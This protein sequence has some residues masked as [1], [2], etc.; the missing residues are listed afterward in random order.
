MAVLHRAETGEM[1]L[2]GKHSEEARKKM[3]NAKK[4]DRHPMFGRKPSEV[5]RRKISE[6]HKG[7]KLSD[8]TRKRIGDARR[9]RKWSEAERQHRWESYWERLR[10]RGCR[11]LIPRQKT[12]NDQL[13]CLY[14]PDFCRKKS[15]VV[16]PILEIE[17]KRG[18]QIDRIRLEKRIGDMA[19][20]YF[21]LYYSSLPQ[22][23]KRGQALEI[24]AKLHNIPIQISDER[25]KL[26][27]MLHGGLTTKT[28]QEKNLTGK[29][30]MG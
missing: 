8:A 5:T 25:E 20:W 7:L 6:A 21:R 4:G 23:M 22:G 14:Y 15:S 10:F 3:S 26:V 19:P 17:L 18:E 1:K 9:G 13:T 16:C 24:Y 28:A 11:H 30:R 27:L 12:N 2:G 29:I